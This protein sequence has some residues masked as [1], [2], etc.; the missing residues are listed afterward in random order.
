MDENNA[1]I[2]TQGSIC[3]DSNGEETYKNDGK[4]LIFVIETIYIRKI[5]LY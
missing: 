1:K 2:Y 3:S 5:I 4:Y